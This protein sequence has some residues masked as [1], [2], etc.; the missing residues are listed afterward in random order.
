MRPFWRSF[1]ASMLAYLVLS[2]IVI[3]I[4]NFI[5]FS[6]GSVFQKNDEI[7]VQE[8]T[9]IEMKLDFQISEREG[10][11]TTNDLMNPISKS[12]SIHKI[13]TAI[14]L[15]K[16]DTKIKGIILKIS[17]LNMGLSSIDDLRNTLN[18]FK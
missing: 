9:L 4:L 8:N 11:E 15:A 12:Y 1:W 17:N 3:I 18:D 5:I 14:E 10:I 6:I 2:L 16:Y 7:S 13:K